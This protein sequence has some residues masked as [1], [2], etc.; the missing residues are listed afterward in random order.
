MAKPEELAPIE[1]C[2]VLDRTS[3][4]AF[5]GLRAHLHDMLVGEDDHAVTRQITRMLWRDY[6]WRVVNEARRLAAENN[7]R[8]NNDVLELIDDGFIANQSLAVRRLVERKAR[9]EP[10]S[11]YSIVTSIDE[12]EEKAHLLTRENLICYGGARFDGSG[13]SYGDQMSRRAHAAFDSVCDKPTGGRFDRVSTTILD[14][15]R[16]R[17]AVCEKMVTVANKRIAHASAP[18]N[19]GQTRGF[20]LDDLDAAYEAIIAV[21]QALSSRVLFGPFTFFFP[22]TTSDMMKALDVALLPTD[23]FD[24]VRTWAGARRE[25]YDAWN[26]AKVE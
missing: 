17:L 23:R 8:L 16:K 5:R 6:V 3:C 20:T 18:P 1:D 26:H 21:A 4:E 25:T 13:D 7:I 11:V 14:T 10:R 24:E 2:D 22:T 15:C 19:R 12:L 9:S